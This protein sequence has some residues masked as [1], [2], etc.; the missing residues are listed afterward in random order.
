ML[1]DKIII[2]FEK[3][4]GSALTPFYYNPKTC[5]GVIGPRK[6]SEPVTVEMAKEFNEDVKRY[7][8]TYK[9]IKVKR[10]DFEE[11]YEAA[12]KRDRELVKKILSEKFPLNSSP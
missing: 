2:Y 6:N 4:T 10:N 12:S 9:P 11:L 8:Q 7:P 5:K 3:E 1:D